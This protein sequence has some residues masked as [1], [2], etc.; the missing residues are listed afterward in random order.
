[1]TISPYDGQINGRLSLPSSVKIGP[2][3]ADGTFY[4]LT[5][6]GDLIAYR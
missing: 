2:V 5:D 1:V 4:V 6:N 3:V